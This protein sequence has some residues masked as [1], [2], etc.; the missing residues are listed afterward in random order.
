VLDLRRIREEPEAVRAALVRRDPALSA[1]LDEVIAKDRLW[2]E[3]TSAAESARAAQREQSERIAAAK[4][5]GELGRYRREAGPPTGKEDAR[6][7]ELRRI[8]ESG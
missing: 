5:A 7:R 2:R 3:A 4:Q 8:A 6:S 1:L